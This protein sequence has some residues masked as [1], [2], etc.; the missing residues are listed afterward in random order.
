MSNEIKTK[1]T[2]QIPPP[3]EWTNEQYEAV[4]DRSYDILLASDELPKDAPQRDAM[5]HVALQGAIGSLDYLMYRMSMWPL[6]RKSKIRSR[7]N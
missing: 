1:N 7:F 2:H 3:C 5:L 6:E 4:R